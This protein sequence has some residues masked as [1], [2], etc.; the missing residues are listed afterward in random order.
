[1]GSQDT[2]AP[3]GGSMSEEAV[4]P[5][6]G[7]IIPAGKNV[8][9]PGIGSMGGYAPNFPGEAGSRETTFIEPRTQE[10]GP[11]LDETDREYLNLPDVDAP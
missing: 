6:T 2:G 4:E 1:M 7:E 9:K 3:A 8:D 11:V 10:D 5:G